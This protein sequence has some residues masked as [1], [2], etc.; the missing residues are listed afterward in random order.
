MNR[1]LHDIK[2]KS[3]KLGMFSLSPKGVK[4]FQQHQN[5][6]SGHIIVFSQHPSPQELPE[7][8]LWPA[9]TGHLEPV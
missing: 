2:I 5:V 9:P 3:D 8:Q 7:Q 1:V 4:R 6:K